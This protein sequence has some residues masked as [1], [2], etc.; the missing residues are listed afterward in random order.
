[1]RQLFEA[2]GTT[3][4]VIAIRVPISWSNLASK[5]H[6]TVFGFQKTHFGERCLYIE[7]NFIFFLL[8]NGFTWLILYC[9]TWSGLSLDAHSQIL[10]Q[11]LHRAKNEHMIG[12]CLVQLLLAEGELVLLVL[13]CYYNFEWI[14]V[15]VVPLN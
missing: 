1:M 12:H 4:I 8:C 7:I 11:C 13:H 2:Y 9:D 5:S 3:W 6:I 10:T 14:T 15:T